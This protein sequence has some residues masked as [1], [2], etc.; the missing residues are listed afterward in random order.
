MFP[1]TPAHREA[2]MSAR[3][4]RRCTT[5]RTIRFS[6]APMPSISDTCRCDLPEGPLGPGPSPDAS[7]GV[8]VDY[9]VAGDHVGGVL[10]GNVAA[11]TPNDESQ[12][13]RV[14]QLIGTH[15]EK[16][17]GIRP[18]DRSGGLG[19]DGRIIRHAAS[20][21][22]YMVCVVEP[23]RDRTFQDTAPEPPRSPTRGDPGRTS[24]DAFSS[25]CERSVSGGQ[26]R[27]HLYRRIAVGHREVDDLVIGYNGRGLALHL[28]GERWRG[29]FLSSRVGLVRFGKAAGSDGSDAWD[30]DQVGCSSSRA[31]D[32][33]LIP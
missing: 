27:F 17:S 8:V 21:L 2:S 9:E 3:L 1:M 22:R 13:T 5:S 24:L 25:P 29:S 15:W 6:T 31:E 28:A 10:S 11:A 14:V 12:L 32:V 4:E 26:K 7:H 18:G 19:E 16:H 30:S 23:D 20:G 33:P